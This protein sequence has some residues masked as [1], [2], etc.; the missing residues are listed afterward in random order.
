M[1]CQVSLE[2]PDRQVCLVALDLPDQQG[3][4]DH[5]ETL[6]T[7]DQWVH[8]VLQDPL[9][10]DLVVMMENQDPLAILVQVVVLGIQVCLEV[11]V[12]QGHVEQLAVLEQQV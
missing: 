6:V 12:R 8:Q 9:P 11:P 4:L 2:V 5:L 1:G 10:L 3:K 7:K